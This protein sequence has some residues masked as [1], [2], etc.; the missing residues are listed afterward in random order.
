[1][2]TEDQVG[3][4]CLEWFQAIEYGDVCGYDIAPDGGTSSGCGAPK[5][6]RNGISQIITS[7][8]EQGL[9]KNDPNA[10]ESRRYA[11]YVPAWA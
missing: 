10:P 5:R 11:R 7:A 8:V 2:I 3:Q 9:I 4:L 1:M 6:S